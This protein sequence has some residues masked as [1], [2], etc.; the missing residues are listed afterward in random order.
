MASPKISIITPSLNQ[1]QFLE[2]TINSVLSQNYSNL[3]Y[4]II[5]GGSTDNSVEIIKKYEP[6]LHYWCSEADLGQYDA[7]N[8]GFRFST[9]EILAWLNSD[10]L[11]CPWTLHTVG[12]IMSELP[13]VEWLT[14]LSPGIWD[15]Y[16]L[17]LGFGDIPGYSKEALLDGCYLPGYQSLFPG[18]IQQESTFWRRNLWEKVGSYLNTEYK[19]AADFDLWVRFFEHANL[20]GTDSPLSGFRTQARQK[21]R[22]M[23]KY[24]TEAQKSLAIARD[25]NNWRPNQMRNLSL[26]LKFD[27][28]PKIKPMI[29]KKLGYQGKKIKR[30]Q[31]N[32]SSAYWR[33]QEYSFLGIYHE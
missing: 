29:A 23:E 30:E 6:Y 14:T 17:C 21:S 31:P 12:S 24:I 3:E 20:Y 8:K 18:F 22:Q 16:G 28:I 5:D 33:V 27:R 11:Y 9:G 13:Q 7:I 4:I 25:K 32:S 26:K 2:S 19:L 10:D 1:E 15:W